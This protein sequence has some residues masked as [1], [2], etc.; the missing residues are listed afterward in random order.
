[1]LGSRLLG[2]EDG[3]WKEAIHA[4]FLNFS[5]KR[6][7]AS[8]SPPRKR[9]G[10]HFDSSTPISERL[11]MRNWSL[12]TLMSE[13]FSTGADTDFGGSPFLSTKTCNF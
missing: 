11:G 6:L 3:L 13:N 7:R 9:F 4:S 5:S 1:M 10:P 2:L 12:A 8:V